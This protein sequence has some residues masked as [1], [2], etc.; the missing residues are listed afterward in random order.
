MQIAAG[1]LGVLLAAAAATLA[2][3][4]PAALA[5][6]AMKISVVSNCADLVSGGDA[7]LE[8]HLPRGVSLDHVRVT[9]GRRNVTGAFEVTADGR[10]LG[11]VDGLR[12]G[13]NE[14]VARA[15]GA[16][17]GRAV[18][19]NHPN[20]GP[21]FSGPRSSRG[22]ASRPPSTSSATSRRATAS[23]TAPPAASGSATTRPTRRA[24]SR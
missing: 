16:K 24:T 10:V 22:A 3:L 21:V 15:K 8:L 20:G 23:T 9:H 4:A 2:S 14:I 1:R 19:V 18:I 5:A 11:L 6:E 12:L 17:P 13:R 7:L